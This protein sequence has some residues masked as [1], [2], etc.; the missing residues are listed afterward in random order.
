M[1]DATRII[2]ST[3]SPAVAGEPMHHAPVFAA[4]FH[5]PG[6]PAAAAYSYARSHNPTWTALEAAIAG[7]ESRAELVPEL[8]RGAGLGSGSGAG[9]AAGAGPVPFAAQA[10][11]FGS[12][13]AAVAAVFGAVLRAGDVVVLPSDGYFAARGMIEEQFVPRGVTVR[14]ASTAG[15]E[16]AGRDGLFEGA[17]L[18]WVETPSN[19]TMEVADIRAICAAARAA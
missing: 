14:W 8:E 17:R 13:M 10:L 3:L 19:P 1:R 4:P 18:L 12:G 6:D 11:V 9:L 16:R 5:T 7:L 2:R 15:M